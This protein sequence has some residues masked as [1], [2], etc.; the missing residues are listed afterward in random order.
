MAN[1]LQMHT[2]IIVVIRIHCVL[3]VI[4]HICNCLSILCPDNIFV[5]CILCNYLNFSIAHFVQVVVMR[6]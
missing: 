6:D 4:Q 1:S 2:A 3:K 5:R